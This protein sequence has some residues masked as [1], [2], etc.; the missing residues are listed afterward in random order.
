MFMR[1]YLDTVRLKIRV[2]WLS[3]PGDRK[4]SLVKGLIANILGFASHTVSVTATYI[5]AYFQKC[6]YLPQTRIN[7]QGWLCVNKTLF[8]NLA[9]RLDLAHRL[10]LADWCQ[11]QPPI[12]PLASPC[13]QL[14]LLYL[15]SCTPSSCHISLSVLQNCEGFFHLRILL[16]LF[17]LSGTF[18]HQ[19]HVLISCKNLLKSPP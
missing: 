8:K 11:S 7:E 9:I 17:P 19:T 14:F 13:L 3:K 12:H 5:H 6:R 18:L 2:K 4:C 10:E 16:L 1:C 15:L